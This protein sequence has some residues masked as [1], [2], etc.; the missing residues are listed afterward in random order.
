MN[1]EWNGWPSDLVHPEHPDFLT[2]ASHWLLDRLPGDF[3]GCDIR[4]D[5]SALAWILQGLI[6]GQIDIFRQ[7]YGTARGQ[8]PTSDMPGL[9][10]G[11]SRVGATLVRTQREVI[12][13]SAALGSDTGGTV[14]TDLG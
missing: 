2:Q 3:R 1:N 6:R 7:L 5:P 9:L 4:A 14:D 12:L 11:L 10:D 8:A 13:V